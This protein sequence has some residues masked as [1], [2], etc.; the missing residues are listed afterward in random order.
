MNT[1][2]ITSEKES[3][4]ELTPVLPSDFEG[5]YDADEELKEIASYI[6]DTT[7]HNSEIEPSRIKFLYD[8][9]KPSKEGGR[10]VLTSLT[11]RSDIDKMVNDEYDYILTVFYDVWM[12]LIK[13]FN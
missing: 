10:F 7:N 3:K 6:K 11:K 8:T 1:E 5:Y 12:I 2:E 9:K 13:L 4:F